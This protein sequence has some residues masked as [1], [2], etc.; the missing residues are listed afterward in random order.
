LGFILDKAQWLERYRSGDLVTS[1]PDWRATRTRVF[2]D[3]AI[4]VGVHD[5]QAAY[6]GRPN[7]GRFR[8]THIL[9]REDGSWQLAGMHLG[10]IA[11]PTPT[12]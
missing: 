11:A 9:V 8:A 4:V 1:A 2:G 12:G 3:C 10:P 7:N 5:Q 6:R